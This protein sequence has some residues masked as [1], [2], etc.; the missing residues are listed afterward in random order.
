MTVVPSGAVWVPSA[1]CSDGRPGFGVGELARLSGV[2]TSTLRRWVDDGVL[3]ADVTPRGA[4][5]RRVVVP[6]D[7]VERARVLGLFTGGVRAVPVVASLGAASTLAGSVPS[8]GAP[9][10]S[11]SELGVV[12]SEGLSSAAAGSVSAAGDVWDVARWA[13][14]A[15][16]AELER[17]V[18]ELKLAVALERHAAVCADNVALRNALR[19]LLEVGAAVSPGDGLLSPGAG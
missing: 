15:R 13:D 2:P 14:R 9:A 4:V 17:E 10:A 5:R 19:A 8:S 1:R 6:A 7:V 3:A 12:A 16:V 11:M 18:A